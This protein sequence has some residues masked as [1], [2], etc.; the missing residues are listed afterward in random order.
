MIHIIIKSKPVLCW[1]WYDNILMVLHLGIHIISCIQRAEGKNLSLWW[2]KGPYLVALLVKGKMLNWS[3]VFHTGRLFCY[4]FVSSCQIEISIVY[5][6]DDS[7]E[8]GFP[9]LLPKMCS[10]FV[11]KNRWDMRAQ[12]MG[13][14]EKVAYLIS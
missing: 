3:L 2:R 4:A 10:F 14:W 1:I 12:T 11:A 6:L 7:L 8:P 13:V 9:S 5:Q